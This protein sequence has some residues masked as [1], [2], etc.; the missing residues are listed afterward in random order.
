MGKGLGPALKVSSW[1]LSL[2]LCCVFS[3]RSTGRPPSC[4]YGP[5]RGTHAPANCRVPGECSLPFPGVSWGAPNADPGQSGCRQWL[6]SLAVGPLHSLGGSLPGLDSALPSQGLK[7]QGHGRPAGL[8]GAAGHGRALH[9]D[10][11][12]MGLAQWEAEA[13]AERRA[14]AHRG[15]GSD[16]VTVPGGG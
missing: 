4:A 16:R 2:T 9:P 15:P 3:G 5:R 7:G 14:G 1:K 6:G 12:G 13:P 10:T 11:R 8:E